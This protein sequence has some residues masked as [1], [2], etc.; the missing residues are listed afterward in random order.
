MGAVGG[1]GVSGLRISSLGL[2]S[3]CMLLSI[4]PFVLF[5]QATAGPD[6]LKTNLWLRAFEGPAGGN[7]G[8]TGFV[9]ERGQGR[10]LLG[11][12]AWWMVGSVR[13]MDGSERAHGL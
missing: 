8:G 4:P 1:V 5:V 6:R 7:V 2:G 3:S 13:M 12:C 9:E 10:Q 11:A